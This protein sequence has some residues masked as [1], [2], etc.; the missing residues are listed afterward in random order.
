MAVC[1]AGWSL[2]EERWKDI[3][4]TGFIAMVDWGFG[5]GV[6][7]RLDAIRKN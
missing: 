5:G 4:V 3:Q 2:Q 7:E 1:V 6:R